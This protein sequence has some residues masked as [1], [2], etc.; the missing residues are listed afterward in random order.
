VTLS[1]LR[2]A[3]TGTAALLVGI[4]TGCGGG[5]GF[6]IY[7]LWVPTDVVVTDVDGDGR[8][9]VMTLAMLSESEGHREGRLTV[10]RQASFAIFEAPD[11]YAVGRYPW[12]LA[13]ED[14]G[15]GLNDL[16]VLGEGNRSLVLMQIPSLPGTFTAPRALC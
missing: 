15:D 8:V 7:P 1:S 13:V 4:I 16:V 5:S 2:T 10:Y 12:R 9:D 3:W 6:N 11:N 14:D